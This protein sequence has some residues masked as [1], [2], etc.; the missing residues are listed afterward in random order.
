MRPLKALRNL[1]F[2]GCSM[3]ANFQMSGGVAVARLTLATRTAAAARMIGLGELLVLGHRIM[4][5]D[6]TL[7]DPDL[8]PARAIRRMRGR[9]AVVDVGAQ[10][11]QRHAPLAIPF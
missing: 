7:E 3:V 8:D 10:R 6:F 4:L 9:H 1:V 5:E 2:L 11:V